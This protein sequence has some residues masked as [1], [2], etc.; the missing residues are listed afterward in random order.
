MAGGGWGSNLSGGAWGS[1]KP[2]ISDGHD[3]DP[4][5]AK[6]PTG[7]GTWGPTPAA[8]AAGGAYPGA[9]SALPASTSFSNGAG[10]GG[11]EV[12]TSTREADLQKR[13]AAV[14]AK[15]EELRRR[16]NELALAGG[17]KKKNFPWCFPLWHHD[18]A[19]EIPAESQR[20]VRELYLSW[21]GLVFCLSYQVAC[22]SIMLGFDATDKVPSWFLALIYWITGVPLSM[23]LWYRR[24]YN[25]ARDD[26][27]LGMWTFFLFFAIN[28]AF[29]IWCSIAIPFSTARWSFTGFGSALAAFKISTFN[30]TIYIIGASF[31]VLLSL[32]CF[33]CLKDAFMFYRRGGFK[34]AKAHQTQDLALKVFQQS[35]TNRV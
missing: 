13:E 19:G 34:S 25:A 3:E 8:P 33:W 20:V 10:A 32:W 21:W 16:E 11:G 14:K 7:T 2:P 4:P 15:E 9:F 35:M 12:S 6:L 28:L 23:Y 22:A 31:W 24:I 27:S 17:L 1:A 30:G 26:S 18:I 5:S 29:C